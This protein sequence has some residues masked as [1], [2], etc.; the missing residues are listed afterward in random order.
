MHLRSRWPDG[1]S[2]V[3]QSCCSGISS[4]WSFQ[5]SHGQDPWWECP[6]HHNQ[7]CPA[8]H[9]L[10]LHPHS[11]PYVL[12]GAQHPG[13]RRTARALVSSD[14]V[15]EL[16]GTNWRHMSRGEQR[17]RYLCFERPIVKHEYFSDCTLHGTE[18]CCQLQQSWWIELTFPLHVSALSTLFSLPSNEFAVKCVGRVTVAEEKK[19]LSDVKCTFLS[20]NLSLPLGKLI[21][22]PLVSQL[23][24]FLP[25]FGIA[26]FSVCVF[27]IVQHLFPKRTNSCLQ[28]FG[29]PV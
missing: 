6:C 14:E 27:W 21:F 3:M 13:Q 17:S 20:K 29:K 24:T 1:M 12:M 25:C 15:S 5:A 19:P 10:T 26:S 8:N 22:S 7:M 16:I 28:M 11:D 9:F 2:A 18:L 23:H 4:C